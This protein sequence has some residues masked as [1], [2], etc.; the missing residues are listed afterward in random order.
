MGHHHKDAVD[1]VHTVAHA[2]AGRRRRL[3][4][5]LYYLQYLRKLFQKYRLAYAREY[6]A[7]TAVVREKVVPTILRP[8][9]PRIFVAQRR[10][11]SV[12]TVQRPPVAKVPH[13]VPGLDYDY[14]YDYDYS[15]ADYDY[16][17]N[18]CN[19]DCALSRIV[20]ALKI[21]KKEKN[22]SVE[23]KVRNAGSQD[24]DE[25]LFEKFK[26]FLKETDL[27]YED[28]GQLNSEVET[29]DKELLRLQERKDVLI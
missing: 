21:R 4:Q 2:V 3:W 1:P 7:D 14:D 29:L 12:V 13:R 26:E 24:Q 25:I 18:N 16:S 20:K 11:P 23:T 28:F 19:A 22:T 17:P 8:L 15:P 9:R 5:K 6:H 27:E 10:V